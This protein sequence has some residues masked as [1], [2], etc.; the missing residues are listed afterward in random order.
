MKKFQTLLSPTEEWGKK[1]IK[2]L[3]EILTG[4]TTA[5][6]GAVSGDVTID[7]GAA[8]LTTLT[9]A[10]NVTL[11]CRAGVTGAVGYLEFRQDATGGRTVTLSGAAAP[12]WTMTATANRSDL[13][14][15]VYVGGQ[16]VMIGAQDYTG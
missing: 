15:F 16:W 13:L 5:T 7:P 4:P 1:L 6:L 2:K 14:G 8:D 3:E 10:G 12:G 11:T 9:L